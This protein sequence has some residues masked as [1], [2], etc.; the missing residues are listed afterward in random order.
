MSKNIKKTVYTNDEVNVVNELT[1]EL[2]NFE[3]K[4]HRITIE[5]YLE[6]D[7]ENDEGSDFL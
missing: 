5:E 6:E 1:G 2:H 7:D 4:S 3:S